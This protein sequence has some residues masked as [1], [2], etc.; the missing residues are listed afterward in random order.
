MSDRQKFWLFTNLWVAIVAATVVASMTA[1]AWPPWNGTG[2]QT[3]WSAAG[4]TPV[5]NPT[6]S[7][8]GGAGTANFYVNPTS[9][10]D[11]SGN[12][13]GVSGSACKTWHH[14]NDQ[15]WGC[16]GSPPGCPRI[17][18]N[19]TITWQTGQTDDTDPVTFVPSIENGALVIMQGTPAL[20]KNYVGSLSIVSKTRGGPGQL[21]NATF[22]ASA[23]V[24]QLAI[25]A[26][27]ASHALLYK[28]VSGNTYAVSQP[29][30]FPG[31]FP[32]TTQTAEVDTWAS[33]DTVSLN[34][35]PNVN[36]ARLQ[37]TVEDGGANG[38]STNSK[39]YL[40][41]IT[42]FDPATTGSLVYTN[43]NVRAFDVTWQKNVIQESGDDGFSNSGCNNCAINRSY[44][45]ISNG[46]SPYTF[47]GGYLNSNA[48]LGIV[49]GFL[50]FDSDFILNGSATQSGF[51]M[52][53][54]TVYF[55]TNG[56]LTAT[57]NLFVA[58][59]SGVG[60]FVWGSGNATGLN[61]TYMAHL[62]YP[63]GAGAAAAAFLLTASLKSNGQTKVCIAIPTAATSYGTCNTTLTAAQLDTSLGATS[64]CLGPGGGA[65]WCNY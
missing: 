61:P 56:Q 5:L 45:R 3:V 10:S 63:S 25:N 26:T 17:R 59:V 4:G 37:P 20:V 1:N 21:L 13:C 47:S 53:L 23:A 22:D 2:N 12:T 29:M 48:G 8:D 43:Q 50:R 15:V 28:L 52:T 32:N 62:Q 40:S 58:Q 7:Q 60:P 65:S 11:S 42:A 9:G 38:S 14:L 57:S 35:T 33:G 41:Q 44:E 6:W 34:T 46:A 30:T 55:D 27:H 54:G 16:F 31:S 19:F 49:G 64:G 36:F 18:Q 39:L 24:G 51:P